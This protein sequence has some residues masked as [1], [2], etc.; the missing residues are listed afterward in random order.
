MIPEQHNPA[1]AFEYC[2]HQRH[3]LHLMLLQDLR[4]PEDPA[5][6]YNVPKY[7]RKNLPVVLLLL[8]IDCIILC[9]LVNEF[10]SSYPLL[11]LGFEYDDQPR[12]QLHMPL[13]N[14]PEL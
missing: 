2:H 10:H 13:Q 14:H 8:N 7:L 5:V 12:E 6:Q 11:L 3:L 4:F 9:L 1:P